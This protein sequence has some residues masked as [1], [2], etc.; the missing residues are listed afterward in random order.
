M[1]A[2]ASKLAVDVMSLLA[3]A[4]NSRTSYPIGGACLEMQFP[5]LRAIGVDGLGVVVELLV[6]SG[7]AKAAPAPDRGEGTSLQRSGWVGIR[8]DCHGGNIPGRQ[9][10]SRLGGLR[11][12]SW[13]FHS[14]VS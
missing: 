5:L 2:F 12:A 10:D 3:L 7:G 1:S 8:T 6:S 11:L 14:R 4:V 9:T 13:V